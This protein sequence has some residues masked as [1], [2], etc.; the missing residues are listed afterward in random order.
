MHL[1][2]EM[3]EWDPVLSE[4]GRKLPKG[5]GRVPTLVCN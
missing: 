2:F 3:I 1:R 4:R 5:L